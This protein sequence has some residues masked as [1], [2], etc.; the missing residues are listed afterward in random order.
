MYTQQEGLIINK[1][2]TKDQNTQMDKKN[3]AFN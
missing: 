3:A 1:T 2:E